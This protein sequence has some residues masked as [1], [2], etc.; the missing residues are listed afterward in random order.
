MSASNHDRPEPRYFDLFFVSS[1]ILLFFVVSGL[2]LG[3]IITQGT[4]GILKNTSAIALEAFFHYT[5]LSSFLDSVFPHGFTN[6]F[7]G[8]R[9]FRDLPS[10]TPLLPYVLTGSIIGLYFAS[11][12]FKTDHARTTA[13]IK[14]IAGPKL[15]EG[16]QGAKILQAEIGKSFKIDGIKIHP[17]V[18][19]SERLEIQ[20]ILLVGATGGGKTTTLWQMVDQII[21]RGDK[22]FIHDVKSDFTQKLTSRVILGP[23]DKRSY[24]WMIGKDITSEALAQGFAECFIVPNPKA[25]DPVWDNAARALLRCEI[26]KLQAHK[27][28]S[29]TFKDLGKGLLEDL[30]MGVDDPVENM[31]ALQT[32]VRTYLPEAWQIVRDATSKATSSVLFTQGGQLSSLI[33]ICRLDQELEGIGAKSFW[34]DQDSN[35]FLSDK[36]KTFPPVVLKKC[37]DSLSWSKTF[38]SAF[39]NVSALKI[40]GLGDKDPNQRRLWF[41]LD[42]VPQLGKIPEITTFLETGRS[43]GVRVV[44]GLQNPEQIDKS[45]CKED[46]ATWESNTL[47]KIWFQDIGES[48]K[49]WASDSVGT[50]TVKIYTKN[51]T[52]GV[53]P[54]PGSSGFTDGYGEPKEQNLLEEHGFE[55]LLRPKPLQKIVTALLMI[56]GFDRVIL[57]WP[58]IPRPIIDVLEKD[59]VILPARV[60][61]DA[62][63]GEVLGTNLFSSSGK[64]KEEKEVSTTKVI[65]EIPI[66]QKVGQ[67]EQDAKEEDKEEEGAGHAISHLVG[68]GAEPTGE[69]L[70]DSMR[71]LVALIDENLPPPSIKIGSIPVV[72]TTTTTTKKEKDETEEERE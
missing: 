18:Q 71:L 13:P 57:D 33:D 12:V 6:S 29:W 9:A 49:K 37:P 59:P 62:V 19:I 3:V 1:L 39:V 72:Q 51:R 15:L 68:E 54:A 30:L 36:I 32:L 8:I 25:S 60:I 66:T 43:K 65:V 48:A 45:Y 47:T 64:K 67:T 63:S 17:N 42:E 24:R 20:H 4:T 44:L 56:A 2:A 35:G 41:I 22:L 7:F 55:M 52:T 58:M 70:T 61:V 16:P 21:A 34:L 40:N 46:R 38:I 50:R 14:H 26:H 23:W 53:D 10:L 28:T 5:G 31:K 11:K 27:K 69:V